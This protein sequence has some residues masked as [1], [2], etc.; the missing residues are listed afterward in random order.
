MKKAKAVYSTRESVEEA[1]IDIASQLEGFETRALIFFASPRFGPGISRRL[2]D[3][4]RGATVFGCTTAG[5]IVS[6]KMFR[7]SVVAMAL[8]PAVV[9]DV[10][11][12]VVEGLKDG[13]DVGPAFRTL[14]AHFKVSAGEPDLQK[15]VG[16]VLIDGMSGAEELVMD[17]IGDLTDV[18]FVG[19]AAGDDLAFKATSIYAGGNTYSNAALLAMFRLETGFDLIKTQSFKALDKHL[20]VTRAGGVGREV[21]EFNGKPAAIAYAEALGVPVAELPGRFM[22]NP[23]GI[24]LNNEPYVRSPQRLDRTNIVFYCNLPEGME[25]SLLESGDII[26]DTR[27]ALQ[28]KTEELGHIAGIIN[29]DCILRT[30]ELEKAGLAEA[31]GELFSGVPTVGFSTYGEEYIGHINQTATML[32]LL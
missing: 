28:A 12:V 5:E 21:A 17:Q 15:Y 27:A 13:V 18:T 19:G 26:R 24:M 29:F 10:K 6:G 11:A 2:Q 16:V 22:H 20:V 3:S 30:Q 7:H 4:F 9:R 8:G 23:V 32:V 14:E 1:V 25:V 31:Y